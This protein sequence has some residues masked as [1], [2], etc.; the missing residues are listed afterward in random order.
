MFKTIRNYIAKTVG[1][2][3]IGIGFAKRHYTFTYSEAVSWAGCY[4]LSGAAIYKGGVWVATKGKH[5]K[6]KV[7]KA[8]RKAPT[9]DL[10]IPTSI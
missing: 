10:G 6:P 9:V 2:T 8:S 3:V 1:F 5:T 7:L 4:G